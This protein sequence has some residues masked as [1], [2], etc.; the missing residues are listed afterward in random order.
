MRPVIRHTYNV[1]RSIIVFFLVTVVTL[2]ALLYILLCIP[3]IQQKIKA[4]GEKELSKFLKTNVQI[5]ELSIKPFNQVVLYDVVIPDQK[6][7][8][9]I[10]IDVLGAGL[11]MQKLLADK[12]IEVNYAE[13]LGLH[14]HITKADKD[15][16]TNLQFIIDAFKPKKKKEPTKF[17]LAIRNIVI[18]NTDLRYDLLSEPRKQ[19]KFD[20]NHVGIINLCADVDIPRLKNDDFL[21][22]VKRL[23]FGETTGFVVKQ[24]STKLAITAHSTVISDLKVELPHTD[25]ALNQQVFTYDSLKH[26]G[27]AVKTA[28]LNISLKDAKINLIDFKAFVPAFSHFDEDFKLSCRI[29]GD[30][31]NLKVSQFKLNN[32]NRDLSLDIN[33]VVT[34]LKDKDKLTF[35]VPR[36][37]LNVTGKEIN[38]I[39]NYLV[40]LKP[41]VNSIINNL[42]DFKLDA[43]V[44]GS[45]KHINFNG[46]FSSAVG[47]MVLKTTLNM[48]N[49]K[50]DIDADF[51]TPQFNVGK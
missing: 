13:L 50:F 2:Y 38:K 32:N 5:G 26:I 39:T 45:V 36:V 7:G 8:D 12:R 34:N 40:K 10:Q 48:A 42:G 15:S 23:S 46:K 4:E 51:N 3:S 30:L 20:A 41:N 21:I 49:D 37:K 33:G 22:D 47:D 18:R 1:V 31:D 24:I 6:G 28:P 43:A 27:N 19:N 9:L 25:L 17:D 11:N 35:N 29:N 16:P 14:G 44:S